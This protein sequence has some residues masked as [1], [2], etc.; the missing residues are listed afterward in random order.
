MEY[1]VL[2]AVYI[3]DNPEWYLMAIDSMINQTLRPSEIV[4][5]ED[6]PVTMELDRVF[7]LKQQET[8]IPMKRVKLKKNMGLGEAL[9]QGVLACEFEWIARMDADDYSQSDRCERQFAEAEKHNADMVGCNINEFVNDPS[10]VVAKRVFPS[11]HDDIVK[12]GKRRTP[13]THPGIIMKKES[14][15]SAG[16]YRTAHLH[17]DYDLFVRMLM[18]GCKGYNIAEPLVCMRVSSDFYAR[19]GGVKYL[20]TL[21][22]FNRYMY[23]IGWTTRKDLLIRSAANIGACLLPNGMR[24]TLYKNFLRRQ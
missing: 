19:R 5:V 13:F 23:K 7:L 11:E 1:S 6:G 15:L 18:N 21:L 24:D 4:I 12:F 20:Q 3:K 22:S 9:R 2:M 17:E 8:D 16:N 14:I 10:N